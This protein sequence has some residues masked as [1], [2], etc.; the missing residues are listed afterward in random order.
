MKK[1]AVILILAMIVILSCGIAW[2]YF[3]KHQPENDLTLYGNVDIRQ[4]SLAFENSGRIKSLQVQ[5]GDHVKQGQ[6]LAEL[7]TSAL[8]IQKKQA[9][10]QL[11]IQQQAILTQDE[12]ARPQEIVQA[13]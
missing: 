13:K 2:F 4:V 3:K 9:E 1:T 7:D 6:A 8:V 10:A 5:E 11:I 12:G